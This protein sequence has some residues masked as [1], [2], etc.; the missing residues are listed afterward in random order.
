MLATIEAVSAYV[1]LGEIM[2]VL[3]F[4]AHTW[5][6]PCSHMGLEQLKNQGVP[7]RTLCRYAI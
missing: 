2:D 4:S 3:R 6:L 1:T 7:S 5:N